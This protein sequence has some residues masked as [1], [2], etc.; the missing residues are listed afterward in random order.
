MTAVLVHATAVVIGTTGVVLLGPS[1]AGKSTMAMQMIAG[2]RQAGHF[3]TVVSDDQ[4]FL[5]VLNG[6]VV[7]RA[8][9]TIRGLIELRGSGV[10]KID[11]IDQAVMHLALSLVTA[12]AETRIPE[13][14]QSWNPHPGI[15]L[16]LFFID[17]TVAA[18]FYWL[19]V[20]IP[21]FPTIYPVA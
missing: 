20:L 11:S 13:E 5:D 4:I 1:G 21:G 10:A 17:R 19:S 3:A 15:A 6:R 12:D 7:A 16:P 18:P 2:A 9:D 14:N 8:P